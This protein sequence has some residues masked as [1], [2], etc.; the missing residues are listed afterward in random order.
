M[1]KTMETWQVVVAAIIASIFFG[2]WQKNGF[3]GLFAFYLI[4]L[5]NNWVREL[6][7]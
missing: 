3:A 6:K 7:R 4:L 1:K 5:I 2:A